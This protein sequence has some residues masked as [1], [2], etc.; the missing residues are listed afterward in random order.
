MIPSEKERNKKLK[1]WIEEI[2]LKRI[3][4]PE[5]IAHASIFLAENDFVSGIVLPVDGGEST[6]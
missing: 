2:P 6:V 1:E 3:G 5:E 4:K